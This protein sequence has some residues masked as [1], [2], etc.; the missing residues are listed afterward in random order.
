MN[1]TTPKQLIENTLKSTCSW[2][3]E[4]DYAVRNESEFCNIFFLNLL[5]L[6]PKSNIKPSQVRFEE[7]WLDIER[8]S[9]GRRKE[10]VGLIWIYPQQERANDSLLVAAHSAHG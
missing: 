7:R 10:H 9:L 6:L 4:Q 8:P 3:R 2:I 1:Y 5:M